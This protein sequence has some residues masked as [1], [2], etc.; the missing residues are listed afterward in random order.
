MKNIQKIWIIS[1]VST[2]LPIMSF[3]AYSFLILNQWDPKL[4]YLGSILVVSIIYSI[5]AIITAFSFSAS[6]YIV[7]KKNNFSLNKQHYII[8]IFT[9]ILLSSLAPLYFQN[10]IG[11]LL[12]TTIGWFVISF[13][14]SLAGFLIQENNTKAKH[15]NKS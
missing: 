13:V 15:H 10:S 4:G 7:Q 6:F 3:Y 14:L 8:S 2:A 11:E 12:G 9:G 5:F 1:F